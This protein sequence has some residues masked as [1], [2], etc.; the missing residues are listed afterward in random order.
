[1]ENIKP[2]AAPEI[3]ELKKKFSPFL[4]EIRR[5]VY[6]TLAIFAV[7]TVLGFVYYEKIIRVLINTLSLQGINIVFTSPF[8]FIN[9]SISCGV[10]TGLI[11]TLPIIIL[12]ILYFLKPAL[13]RKEFNTILQFVPFSV[14]L[15][16][17]G[18]FFGALIMKWQIEIF[19]NRSVSL[20]I[21]NILDISGLLTTV[22]LTSAFMG[23]GFQFPI[24]LLLLTRIGVINHKQLS[25]QRKWI[26]L[27]SFIFALFLPPDSIIADIV[28]ALPMIILYEFT[29]LLDRFISKKSQSK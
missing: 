8:Q 26:Y 27:G 1:M 24:V 10:V 15:F 5:R 4:R 3:A 7:S 12:Q 28:L 19:L 13:N 11:I 22:F 6:F 18:F 20:G 17:V 23:I 29:L 14:F 16:L 2:F 25:S 21:G 9:L